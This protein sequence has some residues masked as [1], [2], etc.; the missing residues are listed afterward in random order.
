MA[1]DITASKNTNRIKQRS[2][3]DKKPADS[4]KNTKS[5][6]LCKNKTQGIIIFENNQERG[7][8]VTAQ[9]ISQ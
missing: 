1:K 7:K 2:S 3:K 5:Q 4:H 6:T 9:G 8:T